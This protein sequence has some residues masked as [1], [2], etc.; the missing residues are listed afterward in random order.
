VALATELDHPYSLA[1]ALYHTGFGHLWRREP[2]AMREKAL[3]LMTVAD[4][5]DFPIWRA[6]GTCLLG[7]ATSALGDPDAGLAQIGAGLD[8]YKGLRTPPVFWPFVRFLETGAHFDARRPE[9][10][11]SL[12]DEAIELGGPDEAVAPLFHIMRGDLQLLLVDADVQGAM[13]S[14][15]HA[16]DLADR[17]GARLPQ[18]R[19]AVRLCRTAPSAAQPPQRA[20][21]Q[22]IFDSFDEGFT[23]PDLIEAAQLLGT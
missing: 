17:F 6:L 9:A 11:L 15:Q 18:L 20:A 16:Y 1:Y 13:Q 12:I 5:N 7:A 19:A 4:D 21:L 2:Q 14:F 3:A 23:T 10:G 8:Q 22:A